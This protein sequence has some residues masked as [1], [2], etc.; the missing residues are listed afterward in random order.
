MKIAK[1]DIYSILIIIAIVIL[2]CYSIY[3]AIDCVVK[4]FNEHTIIIL[5]QGNTI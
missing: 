1:T 5:L 3:S 2:S 4:F